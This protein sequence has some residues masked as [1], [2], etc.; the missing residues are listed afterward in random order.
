MTVAGVQRAVFQAVPGSAPAQELAKWL[1]HRCS[2]GEVD[3]TVRRPTADTYF[4]VLIKLTL[5]YPPGPL[6]PQK[7]QLGIVTLSP[8]S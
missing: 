2:Q 5:P 8:G 1:G 6:A 3:I 7:L 4:R